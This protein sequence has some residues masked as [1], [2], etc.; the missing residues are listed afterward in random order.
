VVTVLCLC[1][2]VILAFAF[3]IALLRLLLRCLRCLCCCGR[4]RRSIIK[5]PSTR[6]GSRWQRHSQPS[7]GGAPSLMPD[8]NGVQYAF[9]VPNEI[10]AG[11]IV[12]L[13]LPNGIT[14][15]VQLLHGARPGDQVTA[16]IPASL[17]SDSAPSSSPGKDPLVRGGVAVRGVADAEAGYDAQAQ[18][19]MM[20]AKIDDALEMGEEEDVKAA[21]QRLEAYRASLADEEMKKPAAG[22]QEREHDVASSE[23]DSMIGNTP[24]TQQ[25]VREQFKLADSIEEIRIVAE[26]RRWHPLRC[27]ACCCFWSSSQR[28]W[29]KQCCPTLLSRDVQRRV[30]E[31]EASLV[32]TRREIDR[33]KESMRNERQRWTLLDGL[34][35]WVLAALPSLLVLILSMPTVGQALVKE[36]LEK[37][38]SVAP[39]LTPL[40]ALA[41]IALEGMV[42]VN[43]E[44]QAAIV[45]ILGRTFK[46]C[47]VKRTFLV[48]WHDCGRWNAF[49]TLVL[50]WVFF[51]IGALGLFIPLWFYYHH[52][53][54]GRETKRFNEAIKKKLDERAGSNSKKTML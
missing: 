20:L 29:M 40:C 14:T 34:R 35:F 23:I 2:P 26:I 30:A 11:N 15:D 21:L 53:T 13:Q 48:Q 33:K 49:W 10:M 46:R 22:G 32:Q 47:D 12:K 54:N 5:Q 16:M 8:P 19:D 31:L 17:V 3:S 44:L 24:R 36:G 42:W 45:H 37:V 39:V 7:F 25:L 43:K 28:L 18:M 41:R 51:A 52:I 38:S 1:V 4:R 27:L 6:G 50:P 9:T